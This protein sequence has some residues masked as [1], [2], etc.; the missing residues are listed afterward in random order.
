MK[1]QSVQSLRID[2]VNGSHEDYA[3]K[4]HFFFS[5]NAERAIATRNNNQITSEN[6]A[7][8]GNNGNL[9]QA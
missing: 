6:G 3:F 1:F 4:F 9:R 7:T 2:E 8:P 5:I